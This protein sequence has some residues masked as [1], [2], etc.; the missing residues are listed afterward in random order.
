MP[1]PVDA[2]LDHP[3][4]LRERQVTSAILVAQIH[5]RLFSAEFEV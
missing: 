3:T 5:R 4:S 1:D 2:I